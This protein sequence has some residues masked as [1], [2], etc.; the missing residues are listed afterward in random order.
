MLEL[1]I[2]NK[3]YS[4]WSLRA[5][6]YLKL[7]GVNF[8]ET[9]IPLHGDEWQ[10]IHEVSPTGRVP[11]L[12]DRKT[13]VW[14]SLA[15]V[16]YVRSNYHTRPGWPSAAALRALAWSTVS[17]MHSGFLALREEL[18]MNVRGRNPG[19]AERISSEARADVERVRRI[20]NECLER[21]GGPFLF[22]DIS[23]ADVFYSP[24]ALRFLTYGIDPGERGAR[25]TERLLGLDALRQWI[26]E[27]EA[28]TETLPRYD[29]PPGQRTSV[30][31]NETPA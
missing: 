14:D 25:W 13:V 19:H 18:P 3:N 23:I 24:V 12:R 10:R 17:E 1:V 2:A 29:D 20:W 26:A 31:P 22:G 8:R 6:L 11:V 27:A 28:E 15:I 5:W 7:A 16:E 9:R 30:L 4:S 21:S